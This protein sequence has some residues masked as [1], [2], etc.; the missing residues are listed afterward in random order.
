MATPK[1]N[2]CDEKIFRIVFDEYSQLIRNFIY[3]KC[4]DID[5]AED[6]TQDAFVKLW[7]NCKNV[8][9]EK[10]K[11]F[12]MKVAQNS[13]FNTLKHKKV[14]LNYNEQ[15]LENTIEHENPEF[16]LEKK[17]FLIRLQNSISNLP[18][19]E[20]EVFLLSRKDKKT[21]KEIAEI[22]GLTQKAV[23]RRMHLA[24][25]KLKEELGASI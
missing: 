22:I 15:K 1:S 13:F 7:K 5:Q 25:K 14:V 2:V 24:L 18:E 16:I 17:E 23:E 8:P 4:G 9:F 3:Y 11:S 21:Y 6:L 12:V 20:R 19:K 10:A